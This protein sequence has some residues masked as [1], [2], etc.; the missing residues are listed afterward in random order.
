M[1]RRVSFLA[2]A[3]AALSMMSSAWAIELDPKIVGFKL[4]ADIKWTE[5][6]R[7]GARSGVLLGDTTKPGP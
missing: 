4:P 2:G 3:I 5:N 7:L 1:K 6:T